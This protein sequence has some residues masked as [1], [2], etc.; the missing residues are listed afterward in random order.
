MAGHRKVREKLAIRT[1]AFGRRLFAN[2]PVQRLPV[3]AAIL[4]RVF[5]FGYG[6][7][8]IELEFRR[9]SLSVP[10]SDVTIVPGLV[11][12]FY[13]KIELDLFEAVAERSALVVDVGGN[14]GVYA[15]LAAMRA[16]AGRVVTFEPVPQ[17]LGY[18]RRNLERNAVDARVE[19]VAKAVSDVPGRPADLSGGQH[20]N[21]FPL[22]GE[23]RQPVANRRG[24]DHPRRVSRDRPVDALKIDVEGLDGHALSGAKRL[25]QSRR[26]TLFVEFVPRSLAAAGFDPRG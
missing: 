5:R 26:P 15:C 8:E 22:V 6:A 10:A 16:P 13:E 20:R 17:N 1:I 19:V 3:T 24:G 12:G 21:A 4:K 23:C 7:D 9:A 2:T 11:G 14:V 18:L 25:L